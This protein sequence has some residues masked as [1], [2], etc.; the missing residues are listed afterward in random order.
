VLL[1][2]Q[3]LMYE[4]EEKMEAKADRLRDEMKAQ[5]RAD[6]ATMEAGSDKGLLPL[7]FSIS[8]ICRIPLGKKLQRLMTDSPLVHTQAKMEVMARQI[9]EK[10]AP[11]GAISDPRLAALQTRM[12]ALRAAELLAEDELH[13]CETLLAIRTPRG[14]CPRGPRNRC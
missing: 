7:S 14:N 2:Q 5:A 1:E 6:K 3:R 13:A 9:E 4:R 11:V 8:F 10:L 12:E